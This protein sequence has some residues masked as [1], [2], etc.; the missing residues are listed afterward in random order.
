MKI[1]CWPFQSSRRRNKFSEYSQSLQPATTSTSVLAA[2]TTPLP[3]PKSTYKYSPLVRED[4]ENDSPLIPNHLNIIPIPEYNGQARFENGTHMSIGE[5]ERPRTRLLY[6]KPGNQDEPL[7]CS[8]LNFR[9]DRA[10]DFVALSYV[11]GDPKN[12]KVIQCSDD[13]LVITDNLH[14]ALIRLRHPDQQRILWIDAICINQEDLDERGKQVQLMGVIYQ[15]AK[16]VIVWLGPELPE[17]FKAFNFMEAINPI[18]R[19]AGDRTPLQ[20]KE[21][22]E[23]IEE[24]TSLPSD[25]WSHVDAL[26]HR[27]YFSRIWVIQEVARAKKTT[28]LYG[29]QSTDYQTLIKTFLFCLDANTEPLRANSIRIGIPA[30]N[31]ILKNNLLITNSCMGGRNEYSMYDLIRHTTA[32]STAEPRDRLF[33]LTTL[34][35]IPHELF[36]LPDYKSSVSEVYKNFVVLD[37]THNHSLRMLSWAVLTDRGHVL[38]ADVPSWVPNF[39]FRGPSPQFT[40]MA[41]VRSQSASGS[42]DIAASVAADRTTLTVEGRAIAPIIWL[43]KSR[44]SYFDAASHKLPLLLDDFKAAR[45]IEAEWINECHNILLTAYPCQAREQL[46][47]L[48]LSDT[49]TEFIRALCINWNPVT[50]R[51]PDDN[52]LKC[53]IVALMSLMAGQLEPEWDEVEAYQLMVAQGYSA[54]TRFCCLEDRRFG[55]APPCA[56]SGDVVVV[57]NGSATPSVLRPVGDGSY[58]LVGECYMNGLME[59]EVL[60]MDTKQ[61]TFVIQ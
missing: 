13:S 47:E 28:A 34:P 51:A 53:T 29:S 46:E 9:L 37:I 15:Q 49:Y 57:F 10:P 20:T 56:R 14:G 38:G 45:D 4:D 40:Y 55:W 52:D 42:S 44:R 41:Y 32:L 43:C 23:K 2:Q 16:K 17:D 6:L 1:S 22:I 60:Q 8:L 50:Q 11:W 61:E 27:P 58:Q 7:Q 5:I 35:L 25:G 30:L 48:M 39:D 18:L 59:G 36:P 26:F 33:A 31:T 24:D 21:I 3:V 54:N 19:E 12:V